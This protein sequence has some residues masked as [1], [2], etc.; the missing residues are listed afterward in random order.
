MD[1]LFVAVGRDERSFMLPNKLVK[2]VNAAVVT[3]LKPQHVIFIVR[4]DKILIQS[5][6]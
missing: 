3:T 6:T 4:T 1:S 2:T 5:G